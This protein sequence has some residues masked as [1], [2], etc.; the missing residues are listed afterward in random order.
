MTLLSLRRSGVV[1]SLGGDGGG[2]E[3]DDNDDVDA[4]VDVNVDVYLLCGF[5]EEDRLTMYKQSTPSCNA[6][7]AVK[8]S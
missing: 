6:I 3:K 4:D 5:K 7:L 2:N 8:P 1:V